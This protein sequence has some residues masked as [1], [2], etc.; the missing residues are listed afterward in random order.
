[1][2]DDPRL[3]VR[4][5][6]LNLRMGGQVSSIL[7]LKSALLERGIDAELLLPPLALSASKHDLTTYATLSARRRVAG[8]LALLRGLGD[9]ATD[10]NLVLHIVVPSPAFLPILHLLPFPAERI[11]V[12]C[13]GPCTQLDR[14]HLRALL[15]DPTLILPRLIVNNRAWMRLGRK[16]SCAHIASHPAIASQLRRA[17][18]EKI[19]EIP[20]SSF[21][22]SEDDGVTPPLSLCTPHQGLPDEDDVWCAYVGHAHPVKGVDD[23]L[24]AFAEAARRRPELRLLLALSGDGDAARVRRSITALGL[25]GR[26]RLAG[27]VPVSTLLDRVDLLVLPYR[28]AITT[29]LY[30]SLLLE[31]DSARCPVLVAA[32]PELTP[33]LDTDSDGVRVF[34]PRSIQALA[35]ALA[36]TPPRSR[37]GPRSFLLLPKA[38]E[39][40]ER[41]ISAY[42]EVIRNCAPEAS[43]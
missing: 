30:P 3:R 37:C 4:F 18:H 2:S 12:Q 34:P 36:E 27:L 7:S 39:R 14:E 41:T 10:P 23:L 22:L 21:P 26:V 43:Q 25:E 11:I 1:M 29:T 33:V 5:V 42:Q 38:L 31:A 8:L 20:N 24:Q 9:L 35:D 15:E 13:E 19:F 16:P 28:S 40:V 32:I 6:I 17:G